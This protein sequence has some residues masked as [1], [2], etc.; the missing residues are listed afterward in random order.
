M[1]LPKVAD[2]W[3]DRAV[4]L[5]RTLDKP[6]DRGFILCRSGAYRAYYDAMYGADGRHG[7]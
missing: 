6:L 3:T 2:A 1:P 7:A 4:A 5:G